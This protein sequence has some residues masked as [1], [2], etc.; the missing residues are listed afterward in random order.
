MK[1]SERCQHSLALRRYADL[2]GDE[3]AGHRAYV[4]LRRAM[5]VADREQASVFLGLWQGSLGIALVA[6]SGL[7][8]QRTIPFLEPLESPSGR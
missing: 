4:R 3:Q 6:L 7:C 2:S 5:V 1:G 8:G